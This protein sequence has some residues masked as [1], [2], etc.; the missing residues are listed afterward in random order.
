MDTDILGLSGLKALQVTENEYGDYKIMAEAAAS[1]SFSCPECGSPAIGFGKKEQLFM[2][3]PIHGKR[4]GIVVTYQP[5]DAIEDNGKDYRNGLELLLGF[6]RAPGHTEASE[7]ARQPLLVALAGLYYKERWVIMALEV[8]TMAVVTFEMPDDFLPKGK[9]FIPEKEVRKH[10]AV[11]L[12]AQ[13]E[14]TLGAA[15]ELAGMTYYDFWQYLAQFGL[16][17]SYDVADLEDD[18]KTFKELEI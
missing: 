18:R 9:H 4:T 3:I 7:S 16:G 13:K 11:G 12:Y 15:A 5:L 14:I 8:D 1:P 10:L 17:P 2:D 6:L